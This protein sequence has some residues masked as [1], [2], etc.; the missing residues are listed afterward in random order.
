MV[1]KHLGGDALICGTWLN[2]LATRP[3]SFIFMV[4]LLQVSTT[5]YESLMTGPDGYILIEHLTGCHTASS[6]MQ[7][8]PMIE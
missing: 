4:D 8:C 6:P 3:N 7:G 5:A 2:A 1:F